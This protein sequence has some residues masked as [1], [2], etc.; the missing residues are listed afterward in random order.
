MVIH[1]LNPIWRN[2]KDIKKQNGAVQKRFTLNLR[3]KTIQIIME[4]KL[5]MMKLYREM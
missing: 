4:Q 2:N 3:M 1:G 5:H